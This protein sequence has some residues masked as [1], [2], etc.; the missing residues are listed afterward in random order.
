[1]KLEG[2]PQTVSL[3]DGTPVAVRPL[4]TGDAP[5]L[6]KFYRSLPEEDRLYLKD[7]VTKP[8]WLRP[9]VAAV[10][11]G[12]VVSLLAERAGKIVAE[13]TLYRALHGW[14]RHVGEIRVSVAPELR[15]DG[16]GTALARELV[17]V[18]TRTGVEKM[19]IEVVENQVGARK[20]FRK[21]GFRQEAVLRGHVKDITGTKRNLIL[22]SNDVSHIWD[23]MEALV[24]DYSPAVE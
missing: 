3:R 2:F 7:D 13:A 20:M 15:R 1:V 18:A 10:E 19:V 24:A 5:S 12:E 8:D 16:L 11:S 21:L 6:L 14:S 22:A 4:E 9:F 23:A 17:K